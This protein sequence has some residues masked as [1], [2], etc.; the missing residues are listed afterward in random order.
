M[1]VAGRKQRAGNP[2]RGAQIVLDNAADDR[3]ALRPQPCRR[4]V[5]LPLVVCGTLLCLLRCWQLLCGRPGLLAGQQLN[6]LR[7][8]TAIQ[9]LHER[10]EVPA[11][12][13]VPTMK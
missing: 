4:A 2:A 11:D 1:S 9:M 6:R 3:L 12:T 10:D 7:K 13:A 5:P 8:A